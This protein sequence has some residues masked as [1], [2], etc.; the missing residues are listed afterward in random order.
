MRIAALARCASGVLCGGNSAAATGASA[1][2]DSPWANDMQT[3]EEGREMDASYSAALRTGGQE[4]DSENGS[5]H[6]VV[7]DGLQAPAEW[8]AEMTEKLHALLMAR[9]TG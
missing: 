4:A 7:P 9:R 1:D 5:F 8:P 6:P 2:A 3:F